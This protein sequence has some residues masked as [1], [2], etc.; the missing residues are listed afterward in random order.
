MTRHR[1]L[2]VAATALVLLQALVLALPARATGEGL[3]RLR[4]TLTT[5]SDWASASLGDLRVRAQHVTA[6]APGA[7]LHAGAQE[8]TLVPAG[9]EPAVAVVDLVVEVASDRDPR[10]VLRK[11]MV[12]TAT[13]DLEVRNAAEGA[14][15]AVHA[16]LDTNHPDLNRLEQTV[17]AIALDAGGLVVDPV[18]P[19]RLTLAFYYPWFGADAPRDL[20]IG[21]D[22]PVV[23]YATDDP[24]AVSAMVDQAAGAGVDGFVVSW[25]G[26]RHA[27][28]VDLLVDA[29]ADRPGFTLAPVLELRAL[30]TRSLLGGSTFDPS[31]AAAATRDFLARVPAASRLEVDGRP[32]LLAFGMWDLSV[33]QWAAY[34]AQLADL[35]PFVVGDRWDPRYALDGLYEYDPNP[36]SADELGAR[37]ARAVE[38]ARLRPLVDPRTPARLWAATVSPGYDTTASQPLWKARRTSRAGGW[39]YDMTWQVA[40]REPPDW[41]LITSWN[42]WY[43]QTHVAPGT[44]T[45]TQALE[46]T[47]RWTERFRTTPSAG[48]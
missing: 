9:G 45:G 14:V 44:R 20:R 2:A 35:D 39:R 13:V 15:P 7:K 23:P 30:S 18:D 22:D 34:R 47:G 6:S 40:L 19:R 29:V 32:V 21:P 25:E 17:D 43:E 37:T 12:G 1:L 33:E 42:E 4:L 3:T 27:G 26:A 10:L 24:A 5:T 38:L 16:H 46:Q 48:T 36:Y 31:V 8:W 28:P 41:V 11:G